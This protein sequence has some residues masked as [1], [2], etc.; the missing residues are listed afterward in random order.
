[1]QP[2]LALADHLE[3]GLVAGADVG[4]AGVGG[5]I[6]VLYELRHG[7]GQRHPFIPLGVILFQVG[8][9]GGGKID[10]P[11]QDGG[12]C[13]LQVRQCV[14]IVCEC[15]HNGPLSFHLWADGLVEPVR[16]FE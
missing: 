10:Q 2:L 12:V 15:S 6:P 16:P 1:V 13:D 14:L 5:D 9:P 7:L 4:E 3:I 8:R 11:I